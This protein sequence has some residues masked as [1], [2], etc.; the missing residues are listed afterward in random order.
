MVS[1]STAGWTKSELT[2]NNF[3]GLNLI[4]TGYSFASSTLVK[5]YSD[6][7]IVASF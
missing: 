1:K 2:A 5:D 3:T 7:G 6:K 4:A